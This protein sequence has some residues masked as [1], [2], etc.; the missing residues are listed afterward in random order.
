M[1]NN[2]TSA[3]QHTQKDANRSNKNEN[4]KRR[5]N[6]L[7]KTDNSKESASTTFVS[8]H[9]GN[10]NTAKAARTKHSELKKSFGMGMDHTSCSNPL[11]LSSGSLNVMTALRITSLSPFLSL[12][13]PA[14]HQSH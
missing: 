12:K 4:R 9:L 1:P 8:Y 2:P 5:I 7:V 10:T 3:I 14:R 13:A 11:P 6:D